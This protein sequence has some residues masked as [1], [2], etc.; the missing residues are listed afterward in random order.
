M[1]KVSDGA[2]PLCNI[3]ISVLHGVF[4]PH[5]RAVDMSDAPRL[6]GKR[7]WCG[8]RGSLFVCVVPTLLFSLLRSAAGTFAHRSDE[9]KRIDGRTGATFSTGNRSHSPHVCS[10]EMRGGGISFSTT[11]KSNLIWPTFSAGRP[12]EEISVVC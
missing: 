3:S 9:R 12:L 4:N 8:T 7:G 1:R 11:P 5:C 2:L 6:K 10:L